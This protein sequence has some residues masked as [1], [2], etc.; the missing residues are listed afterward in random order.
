MGITNHL[1]WRLREHHSERNRCP[2]R[3]TLAVS[4]VIRVEHRSEA[5][6]L[7]HAMHNRSRAPGQLIGASEARLLRLRDRFGFADQD[8]YNEHISA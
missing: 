7:E 5:L 6:E 8:Q 2:T 4:E 1:R 3:A